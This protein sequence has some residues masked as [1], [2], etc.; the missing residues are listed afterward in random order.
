MDFIL[1]LPKTRRGVDSILVVVDQFSKMAHFLSCSKTF[2]ATYVA[3]LYFKEVVKL[4]GIPKS[5]TSDRDPKFI[6]HFWRTLW[7]KMGT[8]LQFSSC[9]HPQ[10]DGQTE[11]VNRTLGNLL[12]SLAGGEKHNWDFT[13]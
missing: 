6:S 8:R 2:E 9:H 5:I 1:G 7:R 4:H 11:V 13:L 10:T 12:R 3:N